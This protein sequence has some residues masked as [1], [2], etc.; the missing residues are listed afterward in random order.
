MARYRVEGPWTTEQ[1]SAH[2]V[3]ETATLVDTRD[4]HRYARGAFRVRVLT[5]GITD[6]GGTPFRTRTF[7][8]ETAY[9]GAHAYFDDIMWAAARN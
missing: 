5:R 7:K 9:D 4:G 6:R 8:G 3:I 1:T 2:A